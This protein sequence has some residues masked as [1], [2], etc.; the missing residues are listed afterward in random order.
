MKETGH[1][2]KICRTS[3]LLTACI[4]LSLLG[5]AFASVILERFGS[6][7]FGKALSEPAVVMVELKQPNQKMSKI[8]TVAQKTSSKQLPKQSASPN[9]AVV[10]A[11]PVPQ[12]ETTI[13]K[14]EPKQ[15]SLPPQKQQ[16]NQTISQ[17]QTTLKTKT[18]AAPLEKIY[19]SG[20]SIVP[21]QQEKL[22][23]QLSLSGVPVGSAELE[24]TNTNGEI[25]IQSTIRS[26]SVISA[27]YAVN[28]STDTRLIKG[29][30][31]LTR[32]KQNEGMFKSD[33]GFT[34][35]YPDHKIFWVDRLKQRYSNEPLESPDTLDFVSGFYFL[36]QK[37]LKVGDAFS[38]KLYDGDTTTTVPVAVLR[39]EKLPLPG[40]RSAET[41][42][43]QPGFA[44]S[45]FFRNNRDLL[46][47]FTND[48][49]RVPVRFE[50]TTPIGRV[51]AEL[52]SSERIIKDPSSSPV[53]MQNK[54]QYN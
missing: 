42:V 16:D 24:A 48:E 32:I 40:M 8:Q 10:S 22:V 9:K 39:Q 2:H 44:E 38:L 20:D 5:H 17:Q 6:Y 29:R 28:D 52:V 4:V 15:T 54:M 18:N 13:T 23:Y 21:A 47:W 30:Y 49:S 45:G 12:I 35:M 51:A 19:H 34:I 41:L 3:R 26:N 33:T 36:R 53:V 27:I 1:N 43:V 50:A 11:V 25:R 46:V 14:P 7:T 31:L 37:A